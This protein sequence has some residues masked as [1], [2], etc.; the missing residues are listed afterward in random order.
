M[1]PASSVWDGA[2][3]QDLRHLGPSCAGWETPRTLPPELLSASCP[4]MSGE[5]P[6]PL[7]PRIPG[8]PDVPSVNGLC[9]SL[10]TKPPPK[11]SA[12]T[13]FGFELEFRS[14]QVR[15]VAQS[16][17]TL[18]DPMDCS[19]LGFPVHHQLPELAPTHVHRV[20]D[21]I[22]PSHPVTPFSSCLQSFPASGYFP[23]SRL[24]ASDGQS[25][26]ASASA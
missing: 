26:G 5:S 1:P 17:L 20:G 16:C 12:G 7:L 14:G 4:E 18:C 25:I 23:M 3:S 22:L 9:Q 8:A 10:A 21:A 15:S 19:T 24:F 2:P 6:V 13:T 11:S